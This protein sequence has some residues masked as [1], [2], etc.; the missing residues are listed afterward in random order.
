MGD[1]AMRVVKGVLI[2]GGAILPGISGGVLC[3]VMGVYQ[4]LMAF[5]AH[6]FAEFKRRIAYLLPIFIGWGLGAIGFS[7]LVNLLFQYAETSAVW[8]FAGLVAGTLPALYKEAGVKG[9]PR[10]CVAAFFAGALLVGG[11]MFLFSGGEK[12]AVSPS[13]AWWLVCGALWGMGAIVPGMSPSSFFIFFGLYQPMAAGIG[14]FDLRVLLPLA[15]GFVV[16]VA[17]FVRGVNAMFKVA[18]PQLM[19]AILGIVAVSTI[20][21]LP[22]QSGAGIADILGYAL[23]FIVGC[24]AA[25]L[26]ERLG[27][28]AQPPEEENNA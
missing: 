17:L 10:S 7:Q 3:V 2:G 15:V 22:L 14:A 9:R 13:F 11:W 25:L 26:M 16:F 28:K 20:G 6:P 5:L 27:G 21:I 12:V 4:P 8:L 23:C 18:Y 24:G 19:H 1:W